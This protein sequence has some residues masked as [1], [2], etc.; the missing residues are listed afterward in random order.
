MPILI[1]TGNTSEWRSTSVEV[2]EGGSSVGPDSLTL[3]C[4]TVSACVGVGSYYYYRR[5]PANYGPRS[6][7][8]TDTAAL[9]VIGSGGTWRAARAPLPS[10]ASANPQAELRAVACASASVCAAIGGYADDSGNGEGLLESRTGMSWTALEVTAYLQSVACASP[11]MCVAV[12]SYGESEGVLI[13]GTGTSWTASTAPLPPNAGTDPYAA[14]ESVTCP[15][16]NRCLAV[17]YYRD[18]SGQED[19]LLETWDGEVWSPA[20]AVGSGALRYAACNSPVD[21]VAAGDSKML[22]V[23]RPGTSQEASRTIPTPLPANA[24]KTS[25]TISFYSAN[26]GPAATCAI[27][28]WYKTTSNKQ[29]G[30]LIFGSGSSWKAIEAPQPGGREYAAILHS[31]ACPTA[32]H[33]V[34]VGGYNVCANP[35]PLIVAVLNTSFIPAGQGQMSSAPTPHRIPGW[36]G[37]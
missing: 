17:G 12:G 8:N 34:A 35:Q 37:W 15:A 22:L 3:A 33:C 1:A 25:W 6:A 5:T 20:E 16:S 32:V 31:A 26:C 19:G 9:I 11:S 30:L 21:C 10:N 36:C 24:L 4:A 29:E 27:A 23:T 14:L 28:G 7:Y 13:T 2:P 18:T